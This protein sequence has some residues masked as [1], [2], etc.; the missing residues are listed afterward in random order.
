MRETLAVE[1]NPA[2]AI[3]R[4]VHEGVSGT[5]WMVIG[6]LAIQVTVLL[7]GAAVA[8]LMFPDSK[9]KRALVLELAG[10]LGVI[11]GGGFVILTMCS[12]R[13]GW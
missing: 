2:G 12:R 1:S 7:C 6:F 13:R 4:A 9:R 11:L 10:L 5:V 8:R 3:Q